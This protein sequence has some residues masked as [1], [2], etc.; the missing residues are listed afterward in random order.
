[1]IY[2]LRITAVIV[3]EILFLCQSEHLSRFSGKSNMIRKKDWN[4]KSASRHKQTGVSAAQF[5]SLK[6]FFCPCMQVLIL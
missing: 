1:M 4:E 2:E 3:V 6:I 5:F